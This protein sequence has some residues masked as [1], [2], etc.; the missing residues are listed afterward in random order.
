MFEISKILTIDTKT[1]LEIIVFNTIVMITGLL[2]SITQFPVKWF[3]FAL[4]SLAYIYVLFL[5]GKNRS[6]QKFIFAFVVVFWSGF[7]LVWLLSPAAF[8]FLNSFWTAL[9][10]LILDFITKIYFGVHTTLKF[11]QE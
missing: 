6:E 7:P 5:I 2:A 11:A 10:Y 4:S 9:I 1:T 3:F 8:M